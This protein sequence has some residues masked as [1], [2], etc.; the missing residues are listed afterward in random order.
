MAVIFTSV[1]KK[2]AIQS[3]GLR[4]TNMERT[5]SWLDSHRR[6]VDEDRT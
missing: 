5:D 2:S 1:L 6:L 3:V 4:V